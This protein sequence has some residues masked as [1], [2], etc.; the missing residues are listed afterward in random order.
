[1]LQFELLGRDAPRAT[2]ATDPQSRVDTH[3]VEWIL[4][5][6][7]QFESRGTRLQIGDLLVLITGN[8]PGESGQCEAAPGGAID[9]STRRAAVC[10]RCPG[11]RAPFQ[12][13]V[14]LR[15]FPP[16]STPDRSNCG[17]NQRANAAT[18]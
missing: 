5:R 17:A 10:N 9:T 1:M 6:L 18:D 8:L 14:T 7:R 12:S 2:G 13:N 3:S 4:R 16:N 11:G 15:T